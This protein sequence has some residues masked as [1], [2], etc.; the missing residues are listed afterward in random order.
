[1]PPGL[2]PRGASRAPCA[3]L[4]AQPTS[5]TGHGAA[6]LE[7]DLDRLRERLEAADADRAQVHVGR[8]LVA[9]ADAARPQAARSF[10][11]AMR[12]ASC[13]AAFFDGPMP[14]PAW[15][16]SITAADVKR[17]SCGGPSTSSTE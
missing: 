3:L 10:S 9:Q 2:R 14:T 6:R 17:R 11:S 1:M 8:T 5:S 15:S 16:P 12:A 13:S 4:P 7:A